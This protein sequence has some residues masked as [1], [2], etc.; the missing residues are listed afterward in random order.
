MSRIKTIG[1]SASVIALILTA[2]FAVQAQEPPESTEA[3]AAA[4]TSDSVARPDPDAVVARVGDTAIT[5]QDLVFASEAF[6]NELANVPAAQKR[7]VMI[8]AFVNM[9]LLAKA[10][11][12]ANLDE[13]E[14]FKSRVE[15]LTLQ[16]LRN[17]YVQQ[18]VM[19]GLS[20]EDLQAGYQELVVDQH[21]PEEQ[22]HARHILVDE[23]AAAEQIIADLK[24]GASFEELAKEH[25]KDPSGQNGGDLGFF[26]KGQMV[27]PFEEAAFALEPGETSEEPVESQFGWHVIKVEEKRMSEA[28]GFAEVEPQLRNYLMRQRFE[29]VIA[30][31]RGKYDVEIVGAPAAEPQAA[32][33]PEAGEPAAAEEPAAEEP[34]PDGASGN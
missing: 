7:S 3:P 18:E 20:D 29:E 14:A 13:T 30:E 6:A 26:G 10:A 19:E 8:D 22:V 4:Q 28:P 24:G 17:A 33:E 23:K 34:A 21:T 11:R 25:S 31:L 2:F 5:E 9:G 27:P 16:A 32:E 12:D 1:A 15:F